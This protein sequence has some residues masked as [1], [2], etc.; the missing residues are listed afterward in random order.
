MSKNGM[1][2][3]R[4]QFRGYNKADVNEYIEKSNIELTNEREKCEKEVSEANERL[5]AQNEEISR[6]CDA[7]SSSDKIIVSQKSEID[8]LKK[9]NAEL[10]DK[11]VKMSAEL[12]RIEKAVLENEKPSLINKSEEPKE[13][14]EDKPKEEPTISQAIKTLKT[15]LAKFLNEKL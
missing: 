8:A 13:T 15:K 1:V 7:L 2:A 12:E 9:E 11:F 10:A 4:R 5:K 14:P 3:F 6:I